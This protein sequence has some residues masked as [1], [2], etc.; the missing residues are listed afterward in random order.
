MTVKKHRTTKLSVRTANKVNTL[1]QVCVD[2]KTLGNIAS[3]RAS[4]TA[5]LGHDVSTSVVV[6]RA[7]DLLARY[8]KQVKG[9]AWEADELSYLMRSVR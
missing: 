7:L 5:I 8:L 6:R 2:T 1:V 4:Y 3:A 9:E